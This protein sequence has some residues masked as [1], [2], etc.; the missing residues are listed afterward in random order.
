[1][2]CLSKD[3]TD[4]RGIWRRGR[5]LVSGGGRRWTVGWTKK[6]E[7][8]GNGHGPSLQSLSA[9]I[10]HTF[11]ISPWP[12]G[13]LETSAT[14]NL[15]SAMVVNYQSFMVADTKIL[16]E[17]TRLLPKHRYRKMLV[18]EMFFFGRDNTMYW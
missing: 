14:P 12:G 16:V 6:P 18:Y 11:L 5:Q 17:D 15:P 3:P 2:F 7:E 13:T 8:G 1:M 9:L 10:G 4:G